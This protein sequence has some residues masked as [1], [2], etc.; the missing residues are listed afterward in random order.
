[1]KKAIGNMFQKKQN[2]PLELFITGESAKVTKSKFNLF[3][4]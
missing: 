1:M 4:F 3:G 2:L